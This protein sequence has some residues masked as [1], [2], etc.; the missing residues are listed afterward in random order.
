MKILILFATNSGGTEVVGK[1]I[2]EVL[3]SKGHEV[4][5]QKV[6]DA[7][8]SSLSSYDLLV[9]GSPTWDY[10]TKEGQPH[11][12]FFPFMEKAAGQNFIG[13]KFAVFGLGDT[14]YAHFCGAVP[15][16]EDFLKKNGGRLVLA[17]LKIDQFFF[18]EEKNNQLVKEWAEKLAQSL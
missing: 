8:V 6:K 4:F 17:S 2:E 18:Q 5:C 15:I 10:Q 13:K 7:D 3:K 11:E 12:D 14:S 9:L 16:L 1:M